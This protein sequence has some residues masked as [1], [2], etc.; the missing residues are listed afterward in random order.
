MKFVKTA[1]LAFY[2]VAEGALVTPAEPD[3]VEQQKES[4]LVRVEQVEEFDLEA[5]LRQN[6]L[7]RLKTSV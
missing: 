3:L 5:Y 2:R 1:F 7:Y 6:L 4:R